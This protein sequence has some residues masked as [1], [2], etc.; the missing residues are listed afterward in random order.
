MSAERQRMSNQRNDVPGLQAEG[1]F[2]VL[3]FVIST[4]DNSNYN[5]QQ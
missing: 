5:Y 2:Q 3:V 4:V 1:L